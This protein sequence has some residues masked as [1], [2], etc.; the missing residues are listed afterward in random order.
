MAAKNENVSWFLSF[1][2]HVF[3]KST[4]TEYKNGICSPNG[5]FRL[6]AEK[7]EDDGIGV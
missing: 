3:M 6:I 1:I 5:N 4:V 2:V 7:T